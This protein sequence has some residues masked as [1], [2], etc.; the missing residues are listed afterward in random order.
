MARL[1]T[2]L[3]AQRG[4]LRRS[5]F[6][7]ICGFASTDWVVADAAGIY[8][9]CP[10]VPLPLNCPFEDVRF[11]LDETEAGVVFCALEEVPTV[12]RVLA[13]VGD[14]GGPA[15]HAKTLGAYRFGR[16]REPQDWTAG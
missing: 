5:Q 8:A 14:G 6:L 7:A 12:L 15:A 4:L 13:G 16:W 2:A 9:C 1:A 11:M 3:V 10:S